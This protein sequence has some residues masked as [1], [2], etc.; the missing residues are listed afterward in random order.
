MQLDGASHLE[1]DP[2]TNGHSH[3]TAEQEEEGDEMEGLVELHITPT[4]ETTCT[5]LLRAIILTTV[6]AF[7]EGLC[8][9]A[10]LH[11]DPRTAEDEMFGEDHQWITADNFEDAQ[12]DGEGE[13]N[14]AKWRRTE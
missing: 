3:H 5:C 12:E 11:P 8:A 9:C 7:Y 6:S 13:G 2:T 4:D 14:V 1:A 10:I